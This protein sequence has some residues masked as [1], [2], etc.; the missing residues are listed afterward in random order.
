MRRGIVLGVL[1][2]VNTHT[3]GDHHAQLIYDERG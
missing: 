3:H 1:L 2:I